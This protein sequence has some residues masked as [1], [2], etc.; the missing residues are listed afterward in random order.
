L[1]SISKTVRYFATSSA[2]LGKNL[3][4]GNGGA[5]VSK[6]SSVSS[7]GNTWYSG[8]STPSFISTDATTTYNSRKSDGSLPATTFLTT[9]STTIGATMN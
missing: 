9:A 2:K 6:G 5:A 1:A 3:A 8:I 4:V 7:A